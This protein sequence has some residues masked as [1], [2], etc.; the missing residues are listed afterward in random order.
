MYRERRG[1]WDAAVED[2]EVSQREAESVF[3]ARGRYL[4]RTGL[5]RSGRAL[6]AIRAGDGRGEHEK[7]VTWEAAAAFGK[8]QRPSG[9]TAT[10]GLGVGGAFQEYLEVYSL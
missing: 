3:Q 10:L 9:V 6:L 4:E 8:S 1:R 2:R 5:K 7:Q